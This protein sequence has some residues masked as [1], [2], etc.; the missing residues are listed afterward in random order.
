MSSE[1]IAIIYDRASSSGQKDNFARADAARLFRL[2]QEHG[3]AWELQQEIKSG[4]EIANRPVMRAILDKIAAGHVAALIV[5]DFTRLSRDEDGIDGRIIRQFCRDNACLIITPEKVYDF[6]MD[7]DDDLADVQFLIGKWQKRANL[8]AMTRGMV[9]RARQ[10]LFL[11][12]TAPYG[13]DV[14]V[15]ID[16]VAIGKPV[17]RWL[18]NEAEGE[19]VRLV[20]RLYQV[21]SIREIGFYLNEHVGPRPIKN[22]VRQGRVYSHVDHTYRVEEAPTPRTHRAWTRV[23]I[24]EILSPDGNAELYAGFVTWGTESRSRYTRGIDPIIVHRPELQIISIEQLNGT[25]RL[26]SE[27]ASI[28]PRSVGSRYVFSGVLRCARCGGAMSGK[29]AKQP[30]SGVQ[31]RKYVCRRYQGA[32]KAGGEGQSL[33]ES[34]VRPVV[35]EFLRQLFETRLRLGDYLEDA[36]HTLDGGPTEDQL[37]RE[38]E[39]DLHEVDTAMGRLV[40]AIANGVIAASQAKE[41]NMEL[42]ERKE[43]LQRRLGSM[44][45]RAGLRTEMAEAFAL[46][47]RDVGGLLNDLDDASFKRL[48]RLVLNRFSITGNRRGQYFDGQVTDHEFAPAFDDLL[49]HSIIAVPGHS[50]DRAGA[51]GRARRSS[52]DGPRRCRG[53][54][55]GH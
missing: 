28:P 4:E 42:L 19:V 51:R 46:V 7:A 10:G 25:R 21:K 33:Q 12:S 44:R 52:S 24:R 30:R 43:R 9:E 15:E 39:A 47:G 1:R 48:V 50:G 26:L 23:D 2:A 29:L 14:V 55:R 31:V 27:R 45:E 16:D 8:R 38:V 18:I 3:L 54:A 37:R 32:G 40:D 41:K 49:S 34:T 20:H 22:K 13:Y 36:A 17:R 53:A 6:E 35:V 5:Q 11:P